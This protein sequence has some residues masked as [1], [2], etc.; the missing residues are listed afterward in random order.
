MSQ[1]FP[2]GFNKLIDSCVPIAHQSIYC[3]PPKGCVTPP[4]AGWLS[5]ISAPSLP[6]GFSDTITKSNQ[7]TNCL[8]HKAENSPQWHSST[9]AANITYF[10]VLLLL[11]RFSRVQLC[12]TPQTAAHQAP[13]SLGFSRQEHWSGL[14]FPSPV[15]FYC[16]CIYKIKEFQEHKAKNSSGT[17]QGNSYF[18]FILILHWGS[19]DVRISHQ[20]LTVISKYPL[21]PYMPFNLHSQ[22]LH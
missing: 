10:T 13:P 17:A 1:I 3:Q 15:F 19:C 7:Y 22:L 18:L 4:R 14:P 6:G 9:M 5:D 2:S 16:T 11:S 12:V 8:L 20:S 21:S